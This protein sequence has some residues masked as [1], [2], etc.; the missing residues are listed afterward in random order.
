MIKPWEKISSTPAGD[1]RIFSIR[2]D[3]V[4]SP[5]TNQ[6]HDFFVIDCVNW[7]N[8][9]ALTPDA[10]L[11]M[12]E[13]YRHGSN[14]VELEIPGGMIDA[15]DSSPQAAGLRELREETGYEGVKPRLIGEIFPNPAI[16]S[17]ICYTILVEQCH[18]L[19]PV[20]LD[21][22]EDLATRLVPVTE[23][24]NLMTQGKI[25]HS[26]VAVALFYF[27]LWRKANK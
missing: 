18:C 22:G 17:N 3:R 13:Q 1:F 26:L 14:T 12:V 7:V 6:P 19:H 27:E 20:N 4:I 11:V 9:I 5:R 23:I 24:P 2:S 16:M 15:T 21:H 25:R 8:V 10:H